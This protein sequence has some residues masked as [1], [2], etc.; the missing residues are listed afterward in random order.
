MKEVAYTVAI[1]HHSAWGSVVQGMNRSMT[2]LLIVQQEWDTAMFLAVNLSIPILSLTL[3]V[4]VLTG[5][6]SSVPFQTITR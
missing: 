4:C 2:E 5:L 1:G 6:F 3:G